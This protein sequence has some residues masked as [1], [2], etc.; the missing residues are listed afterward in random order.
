[1]ISRISSPVNLASHV[2]VPRV[3]MPKYSWMSFRNR[4]VPRENCFSE[5]A[6]RIDEQYFFQCASMK[7]SGDHGLSM[8]LCQLDCQLATLL[9]LC[10]LTRLPSK[11]STLQEFLSGVE[12]VL[13]PHLQ[14]RPDSYGCSVDVLNP[15]K[16]EILKPIEP[17]SP[18]GD[19]HHTQTAMQ[20][21]LF[22]EWR[23]EQHIR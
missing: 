12:V 16:I 21:Y 15:S 10:M 18:V 2:Q 14:A 6:Y 7:S 3:Q 5:G 13:R 4:G 9:I 22:G 1:M 19:A 17:T 20:S 8:D 11:K 23:T